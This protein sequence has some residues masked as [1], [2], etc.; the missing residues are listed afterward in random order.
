MP[1]RYCKANMSAKENLDS[2]IFRRGLQEATSVM[3]D[4]GGRT[5]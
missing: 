4:E 5:Q 2:Q 3:T 1:V